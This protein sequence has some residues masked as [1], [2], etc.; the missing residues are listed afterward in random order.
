MTEKNRINRRAMLKLIGLGSAGTAALL[1]GC[2]PATPMPPTETPIPT[3]TAAPSPTAVKALTIGKTVA[4]IEEGQAAYGWYQEWHP[5]SPIEIL[6]WGP[7]G[8]DTDPFIMATKAMI[9]RFM[10]KYPEVNFLVVEADNSWDQ[11][12]IPGART[13]KN[14]NDQLFPWYEF[15][16]ITRDV[17]LEISSKIYISKQKIESSPNLQTGSS[18]I[19]IITWIENRTF[20]DT[21]ITLQP[22]ITSRTNHT[23]VR[24]GNQLSTT[25]KIKAWTQ[26]KVVLEDTLSAANTLLWDFVNPNLYDVV[27]NLLSDKK[28]ASYYINFLQNYEIL[29]F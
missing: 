22:A 9:A 7:S 25:L 3:V 11:L 27:T 4:T 28:V 16:G 12:A 24:S 13:G 10:A 1:S 20:R 8:A 5:T 26:E 23:L 29:N 15:G 21:V 19:R 2:A 14:P 6:A 18:R 17:T